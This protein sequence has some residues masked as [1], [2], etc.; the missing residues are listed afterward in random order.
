MSDNRPTKKQI[1]ALD[2]QIKHDQAQPLKPAEKR[3]KINA[4]FEQAV[5]AITRTKPNKS[6]H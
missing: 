4:T 2:K 3:L 1:E 6:G 5:K